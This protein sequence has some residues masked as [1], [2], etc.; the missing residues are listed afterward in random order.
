MLQIRQGRMLRASP[1]PELDDRIADIADIYGERRYA[2]YRGPGYAYLE[3]P[4]LPPPP[5]H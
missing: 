2:P 3:F 5:R 1:D 4:P